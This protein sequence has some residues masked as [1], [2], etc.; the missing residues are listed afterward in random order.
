MSVFAGA[1]PNKTVRNGK[2]CLGEAAYRGFTDI[3][4]KLIVESHCD[5]T[6]KP[7]VDLYYEGNC[8]CTSTNKNN[9]LKSLKRKLNKLT[10]ETNAKNK[11]LSDRRS[12]LESDP[13]KESINQ[14]YFKMIHEDGSSSEES[15]VGGV[16]L[17]MIP[18]S[19]L[20]ELEWDEDIG[21]VAAST[22]EDESV[23]SMYKLVYLQAFIYSH[24]F[25]CIK[26]FI[27]S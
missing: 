13:S 23:A 3:A 27:P 4:K 6:T 17:P 9:T 25:I 19:P 24:L 21:N 12:K 18:I 22:S 16:T 1:N 10:I 8:A 14:G 20:T 5:N 11:T 2:T 26:L 15:Q 7:I